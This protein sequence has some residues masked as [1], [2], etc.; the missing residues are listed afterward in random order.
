MVQIGARHHLWSCEN[1]MFAHFEPHVA[2]LKRRLMQSEIRPMLV[3]S[4]RLSPNLLK[5]SRS[6]D[7]TPPFWA[8][9]WSHLTE[10][11]GSSQQNRGCYWNLMSQV[12]CQH[13]FCQYVQFYL[14][15]CVWTIFSVLVCL[16]LTSHVWWWTLW[17]FICAKYWCRPPT[18]VGWGPSWSHRTDCEIRT[19]QVGWDHLWNHVREQILFVLIPTHEV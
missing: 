1:L 15:M 17:G 6:C 19:D 8:I 3:K 12:H 7:L 9:G 4:A 11:W 5:S 10:V 14:Q 18:L 2:Q 16:S 13:S